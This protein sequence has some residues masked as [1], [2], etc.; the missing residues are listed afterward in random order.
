V[1]PQYQLPMVNLNS[2]TCAWTPQKHVHTRTTVR[3]EARQSNTRN[4]RKRSSSSPTLTKPHNLE[5]GVLGVSEQEYGSIQ[6]GR[7]GGVIAPT[8]R[9]SLQLQAME[10]L[11]IHN[12]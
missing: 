10:V 11:G 9:R 7:G 8:A 12:G 1:T 3:G 5:P 6:N 2:K 4:L